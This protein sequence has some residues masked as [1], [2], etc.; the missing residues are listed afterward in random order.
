MSHLQMIEYAY[1][2][3]NTNKDEIW[4]WITSATSNSCKFLPR[5]SCPQYLGSGT[6]SGRTLTILIGEYPLP[7][8]DDPYTL[9]NVGNP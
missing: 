6:Q 3:T 5:C 1:A 8:P 9:N 7:L 2:I 4:R